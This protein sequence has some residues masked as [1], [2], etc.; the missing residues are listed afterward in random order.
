M[1]LGVC[2][3]GLSGNGLLHAHSLVPRLWLVYI[4]LHMSYTSHPCEQILDKKQLQGEKDSVAL[5]LEGTV[6]HG[7]EGPAL[8]HKAA[9][10]PLDR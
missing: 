4:L 1:P 7:Q 6:H 5:W 9:C 8:V 10:S 2:Q 3:P